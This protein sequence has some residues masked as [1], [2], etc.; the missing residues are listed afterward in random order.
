[1]ATV[2]SF[3]LKPI[4]ESSAKLLLD[5]AH[6]LAPRGGLRRIAGPYHLLQEAVGE[7]T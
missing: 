7:A 1:M 6:D 4:A 5:E 2:C 3:D